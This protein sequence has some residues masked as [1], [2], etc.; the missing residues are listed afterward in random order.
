MR[1]NTKNN[2]SAAK[3]PKKTKTIKS[4]CFS[5]INS[6]LSTNETT[7]NLVLLQEVLPNAGL[8]EGQQESRLSCLIDQITLNVFS[9]SLNLQPAVNTTIQ[10]LTR[11]FM[12]SDNKANKV[13]VLI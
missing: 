1:M 12:A 4:T 7:C 11:P 13:G 10:I 5:S 8:L 2:P 3:I 6:T 9:L